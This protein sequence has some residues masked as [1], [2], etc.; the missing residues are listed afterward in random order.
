MAIKIDIPGVGEV[1]VEGAAQESTMQQI[2]AAVSKSD[3]SKRKEESARAEADKK[4]LD[5]KKKETD[6]TKD[7]TSQLEKFIKRAKEEQEKY[8]SASK[9]WDTLMSDLSDSGVAVK[10]AVKNIGVSA[11][12]IFA[13]MITTYDDL[14]KNPIQAG[15][16]ILQTVINLTSQVAKVGVDIIVAMGKAA[17]GWIPFIGGGLADI[18]G[19][20]GDLAKQVIDF[21]NQI[22]TAAN[23]VL[24]AEFQKRADQLRD[25]TKISASFAGGMTQMAA[26]ANQSGVGIVNFTA[27]VVAS[28]EEITA[29]GLD[30]GSATKLLSQGMGALGTAVGK[31]GKVVRDE[32]MALGYDYQAQG[33]IM[34]QYMAQQRAAGAK[35]SAARG[36]RRV[37]GGMGERRDSAAGG[38]GGGACAGAP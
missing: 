12:G 22:A 20:F 15:K 16:G 37:C 24:A 27:A 4:S 2:L 25:F 3:K 36:R 29:M 34:A 1:T 17:V 30:A 38:A 35:G 7:Q 26:L 10:A 8:K 19:A 13:S 32:L 21:A 18:V 5:A 6:A 33:K 14:A 9:T 11:A 31:G 28:R 23:E